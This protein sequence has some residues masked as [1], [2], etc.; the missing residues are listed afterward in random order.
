MR[1]CTLF[2]LVGC[3][4]EGLPDPVD[5]PWVAT[6]A[7]AASRQVT[8]GCVWDGDTFDLDRCGGERLRMLG[9]DAPEVAHADSAAECGGEDARSALAAWLDGSE[10][11]LGFDGRCTDD[12]G[13]TLA[14]V[15]TQDD[16]G[17]PVL[18]NAWML[19]QGYVRLYRGYAAQTLRLEAQLVA[20]E[21][22]ARAAGRG[23]W[24]GC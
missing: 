10:V 6:G 16:E 4:P 1:V 18:V 8:V 23:I 15:W 13:R 24:S 12:F 21:D 9:I 20:A 2:W 3:A 14:Y 11:D 19:Q 7:C 5:V 22:R 17:H